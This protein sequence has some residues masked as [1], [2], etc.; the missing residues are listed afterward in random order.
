MGENFKMSY[1]MAGLF[2]RLMTINDMK[3]AYIITGH[4]RSGENL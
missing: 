1:Y 3:V 2:Q 4:T